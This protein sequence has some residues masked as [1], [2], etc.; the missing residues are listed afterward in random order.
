MGVLLC[1]GKV[2]VGWLVLMFIGTNLIGFAV[3]GL[4]HPIHRYEAAHPFIEAEV[5]KARKTAGVVGVL[6]ALLIVVYVALLWR[7]L[8]LG[9]ASAAVMLMLARLPDVLWENLSNQNP[10]SLIASAMTVL[11]LPV[12]WLSLC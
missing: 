10:I 3:G 1:A 6:F 4:V 11:A 5:T 7:Y 12:V 2:V 9:V 8:N